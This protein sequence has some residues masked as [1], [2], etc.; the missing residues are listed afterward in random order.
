VI[1]CRDRRR[2]RECAC[3]ADLV[4]GACRAYAG[5]YPH[6]WEYPGRTRMCFAAERDV[7]E[8]NSCGWGVP[9]L[10]P[11]I[12]KPDAAEHAGQAAGTAVPVRIPGLPPDSQGDR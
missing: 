3:R 4:L 8:R 7:H 10:P 6:S 1:V 2:A 9:A 11:A 12:R 5:D